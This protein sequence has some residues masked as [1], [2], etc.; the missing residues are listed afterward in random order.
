VGHGEK[1]R[2]E[3]EID[4][5][6]YMQ[7]LYLDRQKERRTFLGTERDKMHLHSDA[8]TQSGKEINKK[9]DVQIDRKRDRNRSQGNTDKEEEIQI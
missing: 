1:Q 8:P 4:R 9:R 7:H 3:K 5:Q 2:R 6:A